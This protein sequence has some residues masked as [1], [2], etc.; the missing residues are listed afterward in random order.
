[1]VYNPYQK[2]LSCGYEWKSR[3]SVPKM[4]PRCKTRKIEIAHEK[5]EMVI[6][7]RA[8]NRIRH[9]YEEL[10]HIQ[11]RRHD[12]LINKQEQIKQ[13]KEFI[14]AISSSIKKSLYDDFIEEGK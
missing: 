12:G 13:S 7:D 3:T 6:M 11:C 5:D 8:F 1:M 14:A 10:I 2:C 4:C 9:F